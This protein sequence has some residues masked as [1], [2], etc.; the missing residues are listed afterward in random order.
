[1]L[2]FPFLTVPSSRFSAAFIMLANKLG[3]EPVKSTPDNPDV[4]NSIT[5]FVSLDIAVLTK[6]LTTVSPRSAV[7]ALSV[8][9]P[10]SVLDLRSLV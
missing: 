3:E 4:S 8:P 6:A 2:A 7:P 9:L 5:A 10:S 1:M